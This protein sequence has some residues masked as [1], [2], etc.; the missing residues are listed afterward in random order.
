MAQTIL[1]SARA[2]SPEF[3]ASPVG[4]LNTSTNLLGGT[5]LFA[6]ITTSTPVAAGSNGDFGSGM[7]FFKAFVSVKASTAGTAPSAVVIEAADDAAM[8]TNLRRVAL[9]TLPMLAG[10]FA[11]ALSGAAPDGSK[12]YA[13]VSFLAG[14][15]G[16]ATFDCSL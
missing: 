16:T 1:A 2:F 14:G 3:D 11:F 9:M 7:Q 10:P 13:R 8:S 6:D 4:G 5:F 15:G 12:R